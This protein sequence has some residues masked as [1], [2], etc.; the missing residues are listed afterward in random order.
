MLF[1]QETVI[2]SVIN[3][4]PNTADEQDTINNNENDDDVDLIYNVD[5]VDNVNANTN[6]RKRNFH[7]MNTSNNTH[8]RRYN[9]RPKNGVELENKD[10][11]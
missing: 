10:I 3:C 1:A 4:N 7:S 8:D 5:L 11:V 2:L 6:R 9:L